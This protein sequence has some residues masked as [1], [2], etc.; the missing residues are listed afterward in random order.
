MNIK[1]VLYCIFIPLN[2]FIVKSIMLEKY[3]RK[4][5]KM[6]IYIFN[7]MLS[8]IISYLIVNFFIDINNIFFN[9]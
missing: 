6:Q 9:L 4:N 1:L 5:S 7:L 3:F 2:I 8:L